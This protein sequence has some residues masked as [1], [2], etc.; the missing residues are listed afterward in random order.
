MSRTG[1]PG[2]T[3]NIMNP[4]DLLGNDVFSLVFAFLD[5]DDEFFTAL[6]C[7]RFRKAIAERTVHRPMSTSPSVLNSFAKFKL[8]FESGFITGN[9]HG[10]TNV[11]AQIVARCSIDDCLQTLQYVFDNNLCKGL[12]FNDRAAFNQ[13]AFTGN[14]VALDLLDK[15]IMGTPDYHTETYMCAAYGGHVHVMQWIY[16]NYYN[17]PNMSQY[18]SIEYNNIDW[19][20]Y[21]DGEYLALD[22]C[23]AAAQNGQDKVLSWIFA[24]M[25]FQSMHFFLQTIHTAF[26]YAA[27][28][29]QTR[30][31]DWLAQNHINIGLDKH[32]TQS[33]CF[34]AAKN[35]QLDFLKHMHAYG[36]DIFPLED[37]LFEAAI[38]K[39]DVNICDW[40]LSVG[41]KWTD[42]A[43]H[44]TRHVSIDLLCWAGRNNLRARR[45][46]YSRR[47]FDADHYFY[48]DRVPQQLRLIVGRQ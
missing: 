48:E 36:G 37:T 15:T 32:M 33:L 5:K 16:D 24:T 28:H 8:A 7:T 31:L 39:G 40:A 4:F 30:I 18:Q 21:A 19:Q 45:L 10:E 2:A 20:K 44:Y 13:A 3:T 12:L 27:F 38:Q 43:A 29:G 47:S 25:Q 41:C 22:I 14:V 23:V 34:Y 26:Y 46:D 6:T 42:V 35:G 1:P 11:H 9:E 17:L